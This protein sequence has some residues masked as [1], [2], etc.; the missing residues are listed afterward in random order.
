MYRRLCLMLVQ[1][2]SVRWGRKWRGAKSGGET[3]GRWCCFHVS[4]HA[5]IVCLRASGQLLN[6]I[7][8]LCFKNVLL[9][10]F[11]FLYLKEQNKVKF[12][13][14]E[15]MGHFFPSFSVYAKTQLFSCCTVFAQTYEVIFSSRT[16]CLCSLVWLVSFIRYHRFSFSR[17]CFISVQS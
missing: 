16:M 9:Y 3:G 17:S 10:S 5:L 15:T 4:F 12:D 8:K 1:K 7:L 14:S 6:A 13:E 11:Y 2:I